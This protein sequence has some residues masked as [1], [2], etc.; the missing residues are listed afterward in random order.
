MHRGAGRRDGWHRDRPGLAGD[1]ALAL[2]A[3]WLALACWVVCWVV[4]WPGGW[5]F[6]RAMTRN[7]TNE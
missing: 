1:G 2:A 5:S 4:C 7:G 3:G 6:W